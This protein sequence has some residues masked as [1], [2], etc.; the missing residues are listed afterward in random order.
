[1]SNGKKKAKNNHNLLLFYLIILQFQKW[2]L[3]TKKQANKAN[4]TTSPRLHKVTGKCP[5]LFPFTLQR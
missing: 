4:F 3:E 2:Q 5:S 1:M